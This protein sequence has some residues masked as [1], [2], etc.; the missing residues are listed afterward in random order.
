MEISLTASVL[1]VK[2]YASLFLS[3]MVRKFLLHRE[4]EISWCYS[5]IFISVH[6]RENHS[7]HPFDLIL[8]IVLVG[9]EVHIAYLGVSLPLVLIELMVSDS[10]T[11]LRLSMQQVSTHIRLSVPADMYPGS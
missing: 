8:F 3:P 7:G 1:R 11:P 9:K 4:A 10:S 6:P 2:V 5:I